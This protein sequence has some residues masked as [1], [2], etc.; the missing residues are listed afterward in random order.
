MHSSSVRLLA[1]GRI[2]SFSPA[3]FISAN[4][5]RYAFLP[6]L[7][8]TKVSSLAGLNLCPLLSLFSLRNISLLPQSRY[9]TD[10]TINYFFT[11]EPAFQLIE[12]TRAF[13][14]KKKSFTIDSF[15]DERLPLFIRSLCVW[16]SSLS[17]ILQ[18]IK[19][20]PESRIRQMKRA[21]YLPLLT[22]IMRE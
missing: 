9:E 15:I 19:A 20:L 18:S 17:C 22:P 3:A 11:L 8:H 7:V 16:Q 5:D 2:V 10:V 14:S 4:I 21:N 12:R 1:P 13:I 6:K